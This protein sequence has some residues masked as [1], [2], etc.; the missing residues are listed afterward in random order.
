MFNCHAL[1]K[2]LPKHANFVPQQVFDI[3]VSHSY[4]DQTVNST[5]AW[6]T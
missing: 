5:A 2:A 4:T 1:A 6:R 3:Q